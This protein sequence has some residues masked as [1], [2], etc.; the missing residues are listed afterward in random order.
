MK[1]NNEYLYGCEVTPI[2]A[3]LI[4]ERLE[5]L[6]INLAEVL[7]HHYSERD[8]EKKNYILKARKFWSQMKNGTQGLPDDSI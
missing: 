3:E 8:E 7:S 2:P 5:A 6:E 4:E 1:N